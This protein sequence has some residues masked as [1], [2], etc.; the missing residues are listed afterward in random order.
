[1][2]PARLEEQLDQS[3]ISVCGKRIR[4]VDHH[5]DLPP[6]AVQP[7]RHGQKLD[8]V[9][10]HALRR[11]SSDIE[12]RAQPRR[13]ET[14]VDLV[15]PYLD[16][17]DQDSEDGTLAWHWQLGPALADFRGPRDKPLLR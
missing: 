13:A 16:T 17:F 10:D 3:R 15:D 8:L 9:V 6:G 4:T 1:V 7:Y 2:E 5:S 12:Q 11:S 14:D